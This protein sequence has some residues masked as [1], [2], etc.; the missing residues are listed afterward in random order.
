MQTP[1]PAMQFYRLIR[2]PRPRY[3]THMKIVT[4]SRIAA[5]IT[6]LAFCTGAACS[7]EAGTGKRP[8]G[9]AAASA[10]TSTAGAADLPAKAQAALAAGNEAFRGGRYD[11][12]L[13]QYNNAVLEAPTNAAPYYGVL[14]AAQKTGNTALADSASA[15][16][17]KLSGEDASIHN[18]AAPAN[19]HPP[20][21]VPKTTP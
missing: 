6:V 15:M 13:T 3:P 18:R 11:V 9:A 7:G 8:L 14:M 17:K 12:A 1:F 10:G 4:R 2:S 21:T 5:T 19:P 20:R 16:I